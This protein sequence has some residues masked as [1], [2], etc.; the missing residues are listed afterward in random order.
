MI[1]RILTLLA[2]LVLLGAIGQV[3]RHAVGV[4]LTPASIQTWVQSLGWKAPF[5]FFCL[6]SC[7]HFLLMPSTLLM[8]VGGVCFG[9]MLGGLLG[10]AGIIVTA[11][12]EFTLLRKVRPPGLVRWAK[13]EG[14]TVGRAIE[15]G[16]P[17]AVTLAGA[18]PPTPFT[19]F[20]CAA[21][22][23][24]ISFSSFMIAVIVGATIRSFALAYF[25]AGL[26]S[27]EPTRLLAGALVLTLL[28]VV[29][30]AHPGIRQRLFPVE[31]AGS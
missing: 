22:F 6:V 10:L 11:V 3:T 26:L 17:M 9:T 18:I 28:V 19:A 25:G 15:R 24:T 16:T 29:P 8:T 2:I 14:S 1:R 13:K 31:S 4:D 30:L 20:H 5:V 21:A 12:V 27:A 23:T 7:R